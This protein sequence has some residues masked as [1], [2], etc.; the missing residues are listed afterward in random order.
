MKVRT[1]NENKGG[2]VD[3]SCVRGGHETGHEE[4]KDREQRRCK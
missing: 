4:K 1:A 3:T 2:E